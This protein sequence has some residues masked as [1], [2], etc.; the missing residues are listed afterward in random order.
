M[1]NR[2]IQGLPLDI[3]TCRY[4]ELHP[5]LYQLALWGDPALKAKG[6]AERLQPKPRP[7]EARQQPSLALPAPARLVSQP[8]LPPKSEANATTG[9]IVIVIA[10]GIVTGT[11]TGTDVALTAA[12]E[13]VAAA[14]VATTAVGNQRGRAK[15]PAGEGAETGADGDRRTTHPVTPLTRDR[16]AAAVIGV[17]AATRSATK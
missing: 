13:A 4:P 15:P 6:A 17:D 9:Q 12:A 10:T 7:Q 8:R 14:A 16:L 3:I 2:L 11:A 1:G 5:G